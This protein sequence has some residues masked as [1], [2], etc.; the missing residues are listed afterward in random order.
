MGKR[1]ELQGS[2]SVLKKF[3]NMKRINTQEELLEKLAEYNFHELFADVNYKELGNG[4][5]YEDG[6][7]TKLSYSIYSIVWYDEMHRLGIT[8]FSEKNFEQYENS[9]SGDT[10]NTLYTLFGKPGEDREKVL[11]AMNFSDNEIKIFETFCYLYQTIGNFYFLPKNTINKM[12][13]NKYRGCVWNDYF[14]VFL[15]ALEDL[16]GGKELENEDFKALFEKNSF[17][18]RKIKEIDVFLSLF[19]LKDEQE[20]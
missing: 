7:C 8:E 16:L 4:K 6:D 15:R 10:I 9:F 13:P 18:F 2:L 19:Y 17:F 5:T 20:K 1:E 3:M 14:D 11:D 12:S